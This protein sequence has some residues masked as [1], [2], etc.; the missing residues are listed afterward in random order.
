MWSDVDERLRKARDRTEGGREG[1]RWREG[2]P[3]WADRISHGRMRGMRP[4]QLGRCQRNSQRGALEVVVWGDAGE[5]AG[6][7][8]GKGQGRHLPL[9]EGKETTLDKDPSLRLLASFLSSS[10]FS[11]SRELCA[12][13]PRSTKTTRRAASRGRRPPELWPPH[14]DPVVGSPIPARCRLR[15]PARRPKLP[16]ARTRPPRRRPPAGDPTRS[17][18]QRTAQPR[19][20]PCAL[21]A[22]G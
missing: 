10:P 16:T 21:R 5:A 14:P 17:S 1:E 4:R 8:T 2:L 6:P 7:G 12:S 22:P 19:R 9:I 15:P 20:L 11:L 18:S 3:L 13:R